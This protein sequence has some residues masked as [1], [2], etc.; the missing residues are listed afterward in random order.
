M[1]NE[2]G[3]GALE[4]DEYVDETL[5]R[6]FDDIDDEIDDILSDD[7]KTEQCI[8]DIE[9]IHGKIKENCHMLIRKY[10]HD[11]LYLQD[12]YVNDEHADWL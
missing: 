6:Y 9:G 4:D 1:L 3:R 8:R 11:L 5:Q 10:E 7:D 12:G 2:D